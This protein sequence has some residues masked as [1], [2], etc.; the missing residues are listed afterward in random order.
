[1]ITADEAA[2]IEYFRDLRTHL[3]T[4]AGR[5][6]Q[7]TNSPTLQSHF[8]E[9]ASKLGAGKNSG[10]AQDLHRIIFA[11]MHVPMI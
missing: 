2:V 8:A 6:A 10:M 4:L 11:F 3:E 1:M 5:L 7:Y 9:F